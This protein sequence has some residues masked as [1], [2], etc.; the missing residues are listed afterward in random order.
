MGVKEAIEHLKSKRPTI[1]L[2]KTQ[3]NALKEY[4]KSLRV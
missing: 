1:H 2:S 3:L 4:K